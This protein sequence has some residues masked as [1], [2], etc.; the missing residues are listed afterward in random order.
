MA[1]MGDENWRLSLLTSLCSLAWGEVTLMLAAMF[2]RF[3]ISVDE[4]SEED[5]EWS[6]H[7]FMM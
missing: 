5:L 4:M 3:R 1:V 2:R 7:L 6:D